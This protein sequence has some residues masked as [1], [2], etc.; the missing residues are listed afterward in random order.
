MKQTAKH[1]IQYLFMIIVIVSI[2]PSITHAQ[3][4]QDIEAYFDHDV[5]LDACVLPGL[6]LPSNAKI[7][8]VGAHGGSKLSWQIDDSGREAALIKIAVNSPTEP[9]VLLLGAYE[10]TIRHLGWTEGSRIGGNKTIPPKVNTIS[11]R[12]FGREVD[13]MFGVISGQ[14]V[15]GE[16]LPA[17][18]KLITNAEPRREDFHLPDKPLSGE[19]GLQEAL[20]KG[21]IKKAGNDDI[22]EYFRLLARANGLPEHITPEYFNDKRMDGAY[23]VLSS[24]FLAPPGLRYDSKFLVLSESAEP[25]DNKSSGK[26]YSI[27]K[28]AL[29]R[30]DRPSIECGFAG[31]DLPSDFQIYAASVHDSGVPVDLKLDNRNGETRQIKVTVN[32]PDQPVALL[33]GTYKPTIWHFSWTKGTQI[34]A[35]AVSGGYPPIVMGL[36][37]DVPMLK[38][39]NDYLIGTEHYK[40]CP[41]I[42]MR[43][44]VDFLTATNDLSRHLFKKDID[45]M[46]EIKNGAVLIGQPLNNQAELETGEEFSLQKFN[47]P[48]K[49]L[50]YKAAFDEAKKKGLIRVSGQED[51][52]AYL[53]ALGEIIGLP[54]GVIAEGL[55]LS[56]EAPA[57]HDLMTDFSLLQSYTILSPDYL[58]PENLYPPDVRISFILPKGLKKPERVPDNIILYDVNDPRLPEKKESR[59]SKEPKP[60][61]WPKVQLPP[62]TRIYAGSGFLSSPVDF[63]PGRKPGKRQRAELAPITV[64]SPQAPVALILQGHYFIPTVWHFSWTKGTKIAA[65]ATSGQVLGLPKDVPVIKLNDC[66]PRLNFPIAISNLDDIAALAGLNDLSRSI[67]NKDLDRLYYE[68]S[69]VSLIGDPLP[70]DARLITGRELKLRELIGPDEP[71][72]DQL[73]VTEDI[74]KGFIRKATTQ[75]MRDRLRKIAREAGLPDHL[76][77]SLK[78]YNRTRPTPYLFN[79]NEPNPIPNAYMVLSPDFSIP[80]TLY[81]S[82]FVPITGTTHGDKESETGTFFYP[83][84]SVISCRFRPGETKNSIGGRLRSES[85]Q[86]AS[87]SNKAKEIELPP[88]FRLVYKSKPLS[89]AYEILTPVSISPANEHNSLFVSYS[90]PDGGRTNCSYSKEVNFWGPVVARPQELSSACAFTDFQVPPRLKVYAAG[91]R[92]GSKLTFTMGDRGSTA[93]LVKVTVNSPEEPVGLLLGAFEPT[94]W[95]LGWT[96]CTSI[97]AVIVSGRGGLHPQRLIGLP[98]DV[99]V[100][101]AGSS[102]PYFDVRLSNSG[103]G[104]IAVIG[105]ARNVNNLAKHLFNKDIDKMYNIYGGQIIIGETPLGDKKVETAEEFDAESFSDPDRPQAGVQKSGPQ[106]AHLGRGSQGSAIT[107]SSAF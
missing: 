32:S 104:D 26:Y 45:Q 5:N 42:D 13:N 59:Y 69:N 74:L 83:D 27:A 76:I 67:F 36:P 105:A 30:K 4:K 25:H 98:K 72:G 23:V 58:I 33:L 81:H 39:N 34:V 75:D 73:A 8:A 53:K 22:Q 17:D 20:D 51:I 95:H 52:Q 16:I 6:K 14:A 65:V 80:A 29:Q 61:A 28:A 15:V 101:Y 89:E 102:C 92:S 96:E 93:E 47:D 18:A 57:N 1:L 41:R 60:C 19:A 46:A 37:E 12:L 84:G 43:P 11:K 70:K 77:T 55:S 24:D 54:E 21:L 40:K 103:D 64:N 78:F 3:K 68:E 56:D 99:P 63:D 86:T 7:Y 90:L 38:I 100:L 66:Q 107:R 35:L 91:V 71:W 106:P 97:A 31:L 87:R 10:P 2:S 85:A 79:R 62:Q 49:P 94:I 88:N 44:A 50:T 48:E 82:K 9:A